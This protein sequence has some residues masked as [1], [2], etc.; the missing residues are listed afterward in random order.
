MISSI[1]INCGSNPGRNPAY[2]AAAREVGTH[3]AQA[4]QTLVYGGSNVGL[5]AA[6]A[7]AALAEGGEVVGVITHHLAAKVAHPNLT[8]QHLVPDMHARKQKMSELADGFI[9]LPGG[10]GTMEEMFEQLTWGQLGLHGKP[11]GLLNVAGYFGGLLA[12]LDTAVQ[13]G[14][15][16]PVHREAVLVAES[17]TELTVKLAA[18]EPATT[19]KWLKPPATGEQS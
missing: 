9:V 15:V 6:L 14:F 1:C 18:F 19:D 3:L 7:D 2:L 4:G 16:K 17:A 8:A 13:E 5:M 10:F 12:F 11:V